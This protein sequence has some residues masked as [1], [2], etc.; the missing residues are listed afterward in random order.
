[1][2]N[3]EI[4]AGAAT[5]YGMLYQILRTIQW[6]Q[7][8]IFGPNQ[9]E[10]VLL[11]ETDGGDLQAI[12]PQSRI[13]EQ[14]KSRRS[15]KPWSLREVIKH[16]LPDLFRATEG[17]PAAK[18]KFVTEGRQGAWKD[19]SKHWQNLPETWESLS[20]TNFYKLGK[21]QIS[22]KSLFDF[23]VESVLKG[24]KSPDHESASLAQAKTRTW[25]MLSNLEFEWGVSAEKLETQVEEVLRPF[26]PESQLDLKLSAMKG[27]ILQ[28]STRSGTEIR[29]SNLFEQ[30]QI[31]YQALKGAAR[32][33]EFNANARTSALKGQPIPPE[34]RSVRKPLTLSD[35]VALTVVTGNSGMGKSVTLANTIVDLTCRPDHIVLQ[36]PTGSR[37]SDVESEILNKVLITLLGKPTEGLENLSVWIRQHLSL[38]RPW[39]T[40]FLD[41]VQDTQPFLDRSNEW[42]RLGIRVVVASAQVEST[43]LADVRKLQKFT[44]AELRRLFSNHGAIPDLDLLIWHVLRH[45]VMAG[46]YFK[47]GANQELR[48]SFELLDRYYTEELKRLGETS[49]AKSSLQSLTLEVF[50][51]GNYPWEPNSIRDL[52]REDR[53]SLLERDFLLKDG[54]DRHYIW[55]DRVLGWVVAKAVYHKMSSSPAQLNELI[56]QLK[57]WHDRQVFSRLYSSPYDILW[58]AVRDSQSK[59]ASE[60]L[61]HLNFRNPDQ[62]FGDF[63]G[64]FIPVVIDHLAGFS[65]TLFD[66]EKWGRLL[67]NLGARAPELFAA[68]IVRLLQSTT[69]TVCRVAYIALLQLPCEKSETFETLYQHHLSQLADPKHGA[70]SQHQR[71]AREALKAMASSSEPFLCGRSSGASLQE[72]TLLCYLA[73]WSNSQLVGLWKCLKQH[74]PEHIKDAAIPLETQECMRRYRDGIW[75]EELREQA[76]EQSHSGDRALRTLLEFDSLKAFKLIAQGRTPGFLNSDHAAWTVGRSLNPQDFDNT[77]KAALKTLDSAAPLEWTVF[78]SGYVSESVVEVV[79]R[80]VDTLLGQEPSESDVRVCANTLDALWHHPIDSMSETESITK[81]VQKLLMRWPFRGIREY[82]QLRSFLIRQDAAE[83]LITKEI[84]DGAFLARGYGLDKLRL[85]NLN[86]QVL[87]NMVEFLRKQNPNNQEAQREALMLLR[88]HEQW[89]TIATF[90]LEFGAEVGIPFPQGLILEELPIVNELKKRLAASTASAERIGVVLAL[91]FLADPLSGIHLT[92]IALGEDEELARIAVSYLLCQAV[93]LHHEIKTEVVLKAIAKAWSLDY[94]PSAVEMKNDETVFN[95]THQAVVSASIPRNNH[96]HFLGA[97]LASPKHT[98]FASNEIWKMRDH[99]RLDVLQ[100]AFPVWFADSDLGA[101]A[102]EF[103]RDT[104]FG[105]TGFRQDHQR[106]VWAIQQL[107]EYDQ[108]D[109]IQSLKIAIGHLEG[110]AE[111]FFRW[112]KKSPDLFDQLLSIDNLR[113]M[114]T[115]ELHTIGAGMMS[116]FSGNELNKLVER[117][118]E[119]LTHDDR[120]VRLAGTEIAPY[121]PLKN[122]LISLAVSDPDLTVRRHASLGFAKHL[123]LAHMEGVANRFKEAKPHLK[124]VL[125]D[126]VMECADPTW[127]LWAKRIWEHIPSGSWQR[128]SYRSRDNHRKARQSLKAVDKIRGVFDMFQ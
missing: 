20:E 25:H 96:S 126:D 87:L 38:P 65:A 80:H 116:V 95:A 106:R 113:A 85:K 89:E 51:G 60:I 42:T 4:S 72:F 52:E 82:K 71:D 118:S 92:E 83:E 119:C 78:L 127:V 108:A 98:A 14:I 84:A 9:L 70:G 24:K 86:D 90:C 100:L 66:G 7:K 22:E 35:S 28:L 19:V 55:H 32:I 34:F 16:V 23:V 21:E 37:F 29:P 69:P 44:D 3:S 39:V 114:P 46:I 102:L 53:T 56:Q 64:N 10:I 74:L 17:L 31:P 105:R 109:A 13:V 50:N 117:V 73:A 48:S 77:L 88:E 63:D 2:S 18:Y 57:G 67:A 79:L 1:M 54:S 101:D 81:S 15:D 36:L 123:Q 128:L 75:L 68:H 40:V 104:A 122:E 91:G 30:L 41:D 62:E 58:L 110:I 61:R 94:L 76:A 111:V 124:D 93:E 45:P 27:K 12:D 99:V 120:L 47:F 121:L 33:P 103:L 59:I 125:I 49:L 112:L 43:Q 107:F 97:L 6:S 11:V 5:A 26:V 115:A 8:L